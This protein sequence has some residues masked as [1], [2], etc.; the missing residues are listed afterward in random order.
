MVAAVGAVNEVTFAPNVVPSIVS[1]VVPTRKLVNSKFPLLQPLPEPL[2]RVE[3]KAVVGNTGHGT[4]NA[5]V[6][7][8]IA[9]GITNIN[10]RVK[11]RVF[12]IKMGHPHVRPPEQKTKKLFLLTLSAIRWFYFR[13]KLLVLKIKQHGCALQFPTRSK[14]GGVMRQALKLSRCFAHQ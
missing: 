4:I 7:P 2:G 5:H 9:R 1:V 12:F 10:N 13:S 3:S 6:G 14:N 8:A 11:I